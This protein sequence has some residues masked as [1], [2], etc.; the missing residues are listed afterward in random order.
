[1]PSTPLAARVNH[2][3]HFFQ[4]IERWLTDVGISQDQRPNL[5]KIAAKI[6]NGVISVEFY[7]PASDDELQSWEDRYRHHL[8]MALKSFLK[9]SNGLKVDGTQWLHPLKSIGP[10]IRFYSSLRI[11]QQPA[12]WFEFGNPSDIPANIDL[13]STSAV[14]HSPDPV[15]I[16]TEG[17]HEFKPRVIAEGFKDWFHQA[18]ESAFEIHCMNH[19][20]KNLGDPIH[21][22]YRLKKP[23]KLSPK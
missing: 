1:M 23:P 18:L 4:L 12:S 19:E 14:T 11:F 13:L 21:A 22:H 8:P 2:S 9:I 16:L 17:D 15:F 6:E 20:S 7:R 3:S 10:A 5:K